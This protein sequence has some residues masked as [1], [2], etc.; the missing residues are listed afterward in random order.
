[1]SLNECKTYASDTSVVSGTEI[2]EPE[3]LCLWHPLRRRNALNSN[4]QKA[5]IDRGYGLKAM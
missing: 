3:I 2:P 1:M 5:S 4:P